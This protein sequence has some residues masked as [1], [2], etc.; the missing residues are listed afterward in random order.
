M[1]ELEFDGMIDW[2]TMEY[3]PLSARARHDP[4]GC[5]Y[6]AMQ[7]AVSENEKERQEMAK[8]LQ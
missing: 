2:D 1:N 6:E 4:K 3:E 5:M 7:G 8:L